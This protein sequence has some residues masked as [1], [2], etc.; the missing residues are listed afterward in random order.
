MSTNKGLPGL[1]RLR[2]S[3]GF[4]Q[5]ALAEAVRLHKI[6]IA[7]YEREVQDPSLETARQIAD[8]LGCTVSDLLRAPDNDSEV[9]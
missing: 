5:K 6:T 7:N 9:A 3:K 1:A 2:K 4:T 8:C